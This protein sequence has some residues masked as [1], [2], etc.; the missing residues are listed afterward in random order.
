MAKVFSTGPLENANGV[1]TTTEES[2]IKVLNNDDNDTTEVR[3][4]VWDLNGTK[5]LVGE[6]VLVVPPNSSD[7]ATFIVLNTA[8][9]EVQVKI[10]HEK[11]DVLISHFGKNVNDEL[12]ADHRVLNSEFTKIDELTDI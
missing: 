7:F 11:D 1:E 10:R 4:R 2:W 5:T 3:I 6:A 12:V 8:Q 9:Y